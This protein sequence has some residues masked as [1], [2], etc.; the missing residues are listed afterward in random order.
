[1]TI[2]DTFAVIDRSTKVMICSTNKG[3]IDEV[4]EQRMNLLMEIKERIIS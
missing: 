3:W 4:K 2:K 1:M